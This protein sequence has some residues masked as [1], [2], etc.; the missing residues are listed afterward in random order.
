MARRCDICS[1]GPAAGNRVSHSNR[2]T[3]RLWLPNLQP[4]R[5]RVNGTVRRLRVCSRCL[6]SGK[7][8]RA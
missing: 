8:V 2:H 6:R 4:V 3:R 5:A 1:K 7:V